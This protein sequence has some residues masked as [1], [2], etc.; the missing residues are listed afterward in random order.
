MSS[1]FAHLREAAISQLI[2][3]LTANMRD[4]VNLAIKAFKMKDKPQ[5]LS[6]ADYPDQLFSLGDSLNI[7]NWSLSPDFE[8]TSRNQEKQTNALALKKA[9]RD[10]NSEFLL[11]KVFH[12]LILAAYPTFNS[13]LLLIN[14]D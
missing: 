10:Y 4:G 3:L 1:A 6:N 13:L 12:S 8:S 11:V 5:N 9:A 7:Q 2:W 14:N